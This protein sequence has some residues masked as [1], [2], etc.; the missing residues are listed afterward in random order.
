MLPTLRW[1]TIVSVLVGAWAAPLL[2]GAAN[3]DTSADHVF[4]QPD[5]A[6]NDSNHGG[7]GA[8]SACLNNQAVL[9]VRLQKSIRP[10]PPLTIPTEPNPPELLW[11]TLP[12]DRHKTLLRL[13][14]DLVARRLLPPVPKEVSHESHSPEPAP[15]L[16]PV[17]S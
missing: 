17:V 3:P 13:L 15:P 16:A 11:A 1:V 5:F 10:P 14:G 8:G 12:L 2:A 9:P 4:G 7:L 6:H